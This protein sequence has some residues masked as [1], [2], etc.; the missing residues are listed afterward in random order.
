MSQKLSISSVKN[1]QDCSDKER[2]VVLFIALIALVVMSLAA[3]ALIR[4]VDTNTMIAGNLGF[5]QSATV[6]ADSGVETAISWITNNQSAV[7]GDSATNGYYAT[8]TGDFKALV[9]A[10]AA[11]ATGAGI[12]AGRDSSG[13]MINYIVQRMCKHLGASDSSHCLYGP[14]G[15]R[16]DSFG[17]CDVTNCLPDAAS[18][19]LM[20][21]VTVK[22][23][24][25]KNTVS[26]TQAFVY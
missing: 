1:G 18:D 9:N 17:N 21:R 15:D 10:S 25:P 22:V 2:G 16:T 6:S 26:Y 14:P 11:M 3:V 19:S 4:S 20:Y 12:T 5:K 7:T 24:G 23:T 8:S 13:N